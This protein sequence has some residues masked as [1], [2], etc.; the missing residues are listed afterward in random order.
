MNLKYAAFHNPR[1]QLERMISTAKISA[2][3]TLKYSTM[4]PDYLSLFHHVIIRYIKYYMAHG[5]VT[6][7]GY[8]LYEVK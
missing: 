5:E 2:R 3:F 4:P 6:T 8:Y 1:Q 7:R